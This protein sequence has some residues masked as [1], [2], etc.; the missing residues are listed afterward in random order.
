MQIVLNVGHD[1]CFHWY[2]APIIALIICSLLPARSAKCAGRVRQAYLPNSSRNAQTPKSKQT[3]CI[4]VYVWVD[5]IRVPDSLSTLSE[6][7]CEPC[8]IGL[9]ATPA[10]STALAARRGSCGGTSAGQPPRVNQIFTASGGLSPEDD[11][12]KLGSKSCREN[13]Q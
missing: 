4:R 8:S 1:S 11:V 13:R 3:L 10:K 7:F 9:L 12:R 2:L 6:Y 5:G